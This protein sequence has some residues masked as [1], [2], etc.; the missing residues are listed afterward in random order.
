MPVY[1]YECTSCGKHTEA[2]QKFSDPPL[3]ECPDCGC[4]LRKLISNTSFVLK[5]SGWYADG[6]SAP[7]ESGGPDKSGKPD[8]KDKP[9]IKDKPDKKDA[10]ASKKETPKDKKP[11][12]KAVSTGE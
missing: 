2:M 8:K 9:D 12:K 5:G 4:G 10:S 1:E 7:S 6:Y 11:E 3:A